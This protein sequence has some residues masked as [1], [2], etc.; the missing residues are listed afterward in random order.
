MSK[1]V[2]TVTTHSSV[3]LTLENGTEVLVV[4]NDG[5]LHINLAFIDNAKPIVANKAA[6]NVVDIEYS[7]LERT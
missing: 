2:R 5:Y 4:S 3:K 1:I 7:P 6:A